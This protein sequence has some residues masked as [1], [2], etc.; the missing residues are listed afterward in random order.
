MLT[1]NIKLDGMPIKIKWQT[2]ACYFKFELVTSVKSYKIQL[3][4]FLFPVLH[5][6]L[7]Q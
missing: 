6:F 7:Y 3:T 5:Q 1:E 4:V 2:Q